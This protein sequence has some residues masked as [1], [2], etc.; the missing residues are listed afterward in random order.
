MTGI[1]A[2]DEPRVAVLHAIAL[3]SLAEFLN[4]LAIRAEPPEIP[5]VRVAESNTHRFLKRAGSPF[6][7]PGAAS[8]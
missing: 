6:L 3:W 1:G 4:L 8:W 2:H 5:P 7:A